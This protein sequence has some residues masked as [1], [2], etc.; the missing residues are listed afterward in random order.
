M[1]TAA[2]GTADGSLDTIMGPVCVLHPDTMS[3]LQAAA[4]AVTQP[5][6]PHKELGAFL[7]QQI[8]QG[9]A[10]YSINLPFFFSINNPQD[11]VLTNAF[12]NHYH[13]LQESAKR[14]VQQLAVGI[15]GAAAGNI[16]GTVGSLVTKLQTLGAR[17]PPSPARQQLMATV[18]PTRS[19]PPASPARTH[20]PAG[21]VHLNAGSTAIGAGSNAASSSLKRMFAQFYDKW[22]EQMTNEAQQATTKDYTI[23]PARFESPDRWDL[24]AKKQHPCYSTSS[25]D[26]G[27]KRPTAFDMPLVW[28]GIEGKFTDTFHG[29]CYRAMGLKSSVERS[30]VHR[31]LDYL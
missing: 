19:R 7:Q 27:A 28:T 29:G 16:T 9:R 6:D 23:L 10:I 21:T 11:C 5:T 14:Q 12:F 26:Y 31:S 17:Q 25:N 18:D 13:G 8:E 3:A 4:A 20:A 22:Q 24:K 2:T 30:R 1:N 15:E